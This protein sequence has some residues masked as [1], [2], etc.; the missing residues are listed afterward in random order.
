LQVQNLLPNIIIHYYLVVF[1][2]TYI[3]NKFTRG[4]RYI[5]LKEQVIMVSNLEVEIKN[6]FIEDWKFLKYK[7][8]FQKNLKFVIN[9]FSKF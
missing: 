8:K 7:G 9:D 6:R 4:V 3:I 2:L 5:S 1:G